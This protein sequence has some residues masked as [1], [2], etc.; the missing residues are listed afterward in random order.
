L[1]KDG[2]LDP[3]V[4][5]DAPAPDSAQNERELFDRAD[6]LSLAEKSAGIGVW[7]MDMAMRTVRATPQFF[8]IV[9]LEP[10]NEPVPIEQLRALRHPD[11]RDQVVN[12]FHRVIE[13]G[14][15]HYDAEYRIVRPDG[16]IRWVY[17]RGRVVRDA[18]GKPIRYSGVDIDITERKR[19]EEALRESEQ[20][21]STLFE[22]AHDLV[23]TLDLDFHFTSVNPAVQQILG[24]SPEDLIGTA[25][26]QYMSPEQVALKKE[27]LHRKL[28]GEAVE[29]RYEMQVID[30]TGQTRTLETNTRLSYDRSAKPHAIQAI[31]R[32]ITARKKYEEHLAFT[33]REL[34]HRA[35]NILAVV[36]AMSRQIGKQTSNFEQFEDRFSGCIKALAY[37]HDLLIESDWQG[38]DLRSLI[39]LQVAPFGGLDG[40]KFSA[41]GPSLML[42]PQATQL[43]GLALH[44][45]ATNA[46]KHGALTTSAGAVAIEW[47]PESLN[48]AMRLIW[49][50]QNGPIV[51][52]PTRRGFGHT[53]LDRMATSLGGEVSFEFPPEGVR[54]ALAIGAAHIVR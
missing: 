15:D 28:A 32:D 22:N 14:E 3:M 33:T 45:L 38:A 47:R 44:E 36:L 8:R 5:S 24:Y 39:A 16:E 4:R 30:R 18:R 49:R 42:A 51:V 7:D 19:T 20:R 31:A 27:M 43:I 2:S 40:K 46:M 21:Y 34:S 23:Y 35:K 13:N 6:V 29:T 12:N 9:G 37:S 50:E 17:G 10:T 11:D 53:V 48:G 41:T 1:S 25:L 54:W 52:P 26:T